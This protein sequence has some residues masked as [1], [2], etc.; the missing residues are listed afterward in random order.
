MNGLP[1]NKMLHPVLEW[2]DSQSASAITD[3]QRY[4][5]QPSVAAQDWGMADMARI[6]AED[7]RKL[8]ADTTLAPTRG[9]PV[10]V[11]RLG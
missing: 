9:Y 11:G 10:V 1:D 4:C 8:G 6:V 7:L 3:L 2:I 5:R